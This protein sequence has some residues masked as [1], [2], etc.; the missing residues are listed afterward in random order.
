MVRHELLEARSLHR[1][2]P[3]G[4]LPF[5]ALSSPS[6]VAVP[7][8]PLKARRDLPPIFAFHPAPSPSGFFSRFLP[9]APHQGSSFVP[10]KP[11]TPIC[12]AAA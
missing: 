8:D 10:C 1:T 6:R 2:A 5:A 7:S 11:T 12:F 4:V 9:S 3:A